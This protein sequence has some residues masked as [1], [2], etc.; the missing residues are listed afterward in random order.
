MFKMGSKSFGGAWMCVIFPELV[1]EEWVG[2]S[3]KVCCNSCPSKGRDGH[4]VNHQGM[5][6][7]L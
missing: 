4:W 1:E 3:G 6:I 7:R 5:N 2:P